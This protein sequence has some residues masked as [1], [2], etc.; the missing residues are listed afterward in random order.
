[1]KQEAIYL[2]QRNHE[3][4]GAYQGMGAKITAGSMLS[5]MVAGEENYDHPMKSV[6]RHR[7]YPNR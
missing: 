4:A 1:M 5:N 2:R 7:K 3:K 6:S